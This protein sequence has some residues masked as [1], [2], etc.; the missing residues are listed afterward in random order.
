MTCET[1]HSRDL[2]VRFGAFGLQ[3]LGVRVYRTGFRVFGA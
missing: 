3:S 1:W 2:E